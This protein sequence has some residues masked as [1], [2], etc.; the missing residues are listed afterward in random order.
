MDEWRPIPSVPGCEA[1]SAGQLRYVTGEL[2]KGSISGNGYRYVRVYYTGGRRR[3]GARKECTIHS[4]V[5]EA[6]HGPKPSPK[7]EVRHLDGDPLNN[8]ASNLRWGTASENR[9]DSVRHGTHY[10]SRRKAA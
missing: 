8:T 6:F 1:S 2:I 7:H 10:F 5:C 9:H 4:L 3:V